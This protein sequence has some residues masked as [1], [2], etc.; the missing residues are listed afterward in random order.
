MD[1][2]LLTGGDFFVPPNKG[3]TCTRFHWQTFW[4][5]ASEQLRFL[6]SRLPEPDRNLQG[7]I[8]NTSI[9]FFLEKEVDAS[10][11]FVTRGRYFK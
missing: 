8:Y 9:R 4:Q 10:E 6:P 3:Q 1:S 5:S 2:L 11:N 7:T